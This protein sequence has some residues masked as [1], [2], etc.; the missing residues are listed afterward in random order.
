[1]SHPWL[2]SLIATIVAI[3]AWFPAQASEPQ[4]AHMVFFELKQGSDENRKTLVAACD[5]YLSGHE[6]TAYYSAGVIAHDMS[7]DVN[8][9]DFDVALHVVFV[10][11]EA[12]DRYQKHPRHLQF[13]GE[14]RDSWKTVRVFD[15]YVSA[16]TRTRDR[17]ARLREDEAAPGAN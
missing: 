13:I 14:N 5:K 1:M 2:R 12:H 17:K 15:S 16:P 8:V 9:R 6:G 10:N 4:L 11:K 3:A 7:R